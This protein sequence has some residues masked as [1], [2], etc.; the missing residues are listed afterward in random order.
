MRCQ[1]L[2]P[3]PSNLSYSTPGIAA[4]K[5][6]SNMSAMLLEPDAITFLEDFRAGSHVKSNI[7]SSLRHT[8]TA[9]LALQ[10]CFQHT[11]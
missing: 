8:W 11:E 1:L 4:F 6:L 10:H 3:V 7:K 2:P 9:N 5:A